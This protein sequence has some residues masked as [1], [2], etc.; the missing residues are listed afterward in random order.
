MLLW[1]YPSSFGVWQFDFG[2]FLERRKYPFVQAHRSVAKYRRNAIFLARPAANLAIA[3]ICA[4]FE[5]K[6]Q[7]LPRQW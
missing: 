1:Q 7:L 4:C 5:A 3:V 6:G 2:A